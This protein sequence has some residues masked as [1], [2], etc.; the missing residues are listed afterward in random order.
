VEIKDKWYIKK[1][2]QIENNENKGE[3]NN[4]IGKNYINQEDIERKRRR[5]KYLVKKLKKMKL[6]K[7]KNMK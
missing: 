6:K 2:I 4:Q 7:E 1:S 5:I 3:K